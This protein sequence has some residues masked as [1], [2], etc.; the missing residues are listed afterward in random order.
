M[1]GSAAESVGGATGG[2]LGIMAGAKS[3]LSKPLAAL[4]RFSGVAPNGIIARRLAEPKA[5]ML[6]CI[7]NPKPIDQRPSNVDYPQGSA[8]PD[9][10]RIAFDIDGRPLTA[11]Y[12]AGRRVG[13]GMDEG[14]SGIDANRIA[15]GLG[16]RQQNTARCSPALRGDTGRYNSG[17]DRSI[18]NDEELPGNLA[19][20]V[21]DTELVHRIDDLTTR[22][23]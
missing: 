16:I 21:F 17:P 23:S 15:D 4:T 8:G 5:S 19:R 14:V 3:D 7:Y 1:P 20:R 22:K 6:P 11:R 10:S 9:G 13:D 12:I 18:V 2:L